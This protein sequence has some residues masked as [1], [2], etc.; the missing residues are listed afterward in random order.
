MSFHP[1]FNISYKHI[2]INERVV[3]ISAPLMLRINNED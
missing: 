3:N 1:D 2:Q